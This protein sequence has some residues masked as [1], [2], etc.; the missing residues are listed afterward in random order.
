MKKAVTVFLILTPVAFLLWLA[1]VCFMGVMEANFLGFIENFVLEFK[2]LIEAPATTGDYIQLGILGFGAITLLTYLIVAPA[3][4]RPAYLWIMLLSIITCIPAVS[5]IIHYKNVFQPAIESGVLGK[6]ILGWA[7]IAAAGLTTLCYFVLWILTM[8]ELGMH[9]GKSKKRIKKAKDATVLPLRD[10]TNEPLQARPSSEPLE[11]HYNQFEDFRYIVREEIERVYSKLTVRDNVRIRM[12]EEE[13]L[14]TKRENKETE[15]PITEEIKDTPIIIKEEPTSTIEPEITPAETVEEI[16]EEVEEETTIEQP[17]EEVVEE[18]IEEVVE[19]EQPE[20]VE[21]VVEE[22]VEEEVVEEEQPEEIVEEIVEEVVEEEQPQE[23]P[24]PIVVEEENNEPAKVYE[25]ISFVQRMMTA[26][27]EMKDHYNELKNE[28][29]AYGVKSRVSSSGDAFR[30]HTKTYVKITIAGKSLKL[31]FA[32]DPKD[33]ED[34]KLPIS[35]ASSK[36]IYKEIPL[37]FKVKSGLSMKR[38]KDLIADA[39]AKDSL[40]KED[41]L[42]IDYVAKLEEDLEA[43][44]D[45]DDE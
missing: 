24:A 38:A 45:D 43:S 30:L 13:L 10:V 29:M 23:E 3:R 4:R 40:D 42:D 44:F 22:V 17:N 34:T 14:R 32:L 41:V 33:Y 26:E 21:E 6:Q 1:G 11:E 25:R 18:V 19:E 27:D 12:L 31:Y 20:E 35:D 28:I 36:A 15:K 2:T 7:V 39:M 5:V 8:I 37:V 9:P 16:V